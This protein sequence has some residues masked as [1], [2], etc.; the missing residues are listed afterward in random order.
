MYSPIAALEEEEIKQL[1]KKL[2][3]PIQLMEIR[4]LIK[5]KMVEFQNMKDG[6]KRVNLLQRQLKPYTPTGWKVDWIE[7]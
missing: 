6:V 2:M 7:S 3:K 5:E 1:R 4:R